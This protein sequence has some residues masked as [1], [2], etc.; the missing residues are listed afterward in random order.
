MMDMN[1][2]FSR[3]EKRRQQILD[4]LAHLQLSY[5]APLSPREKSEAAQALAAHIERYKI[6]LKAL[7]AGVVRQLGSHDEG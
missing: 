6:P 1:E 7:H 5:L 4:K 3:D 2:K